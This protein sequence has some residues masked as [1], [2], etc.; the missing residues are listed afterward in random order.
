MAWAS[1]S[2]F[3]GPD[4][5]PGFPPGE[6]T[7]G[8]A[9][10][11]SLVFDFGG[12]LVD[13]AADIT[14]SV[15]C[16][17]QQRTSES[18]PA[19][20]GTLTVTLNNSSGAYTP[21]NPA[22]PH[23]PDLVLQ[24]A[25]TWSV[26]KNSNTITLFRGRV[27]SIDPT[28]TSASKDGTVTI[29]CSDR[30]GEAAGQ[31]LRSDVN[32]R[33][34]FQSDGTTDVWM[35]G[36]ADGASS[37]ANTGHGGKGL[38]AKRINPTSGRGQVTRDDADGLI[39]EGAVTVTDSGGV[40]PVIL[41]RHAPGQ[42]VMIVWFKWDVLPPYLPDYDVLLAG[43]KGRVDGEVDGAYLWHLRYTETAPGT[44]KFQLELRDT[45]NTVVGAL[46]P[47]AGDGAWH[48]LFVWNYEPGSTGFYYDNSSVSLAAGL[49]LADQEYIVCGG[50]MNPFIRG[51]QTHCMTA[52]FAALMV[53]SVYTGGGLEPYT[54]VGSVL[55]ADERWTNLM[56]WRTYGG[57]YGMAG[58][59]T[60]PVAVKSSAGRPQLDCL[61]ELAT[62]IGGTVWHNPVTD[63]VDLLTGPIYRP[64]VPAAV[65]V[66][67]LDDDVSAGHEWGLSLADSPTRA[68]ASCPA[69]EGTYI[70]AAAETRGV[71]DAG[72]F[73]TTAAT[74]EQARAL[75]AWQVNRIRRLSLSKFAV[76]VAS[77]VYG[78]TLWPA[79]L[80]LQP[81][82]RLHIVGIDQD[83]FGITTFDVHVIAWE[84]ELGPEVARW[85]FTCLPADSPAEYAVADELYGRIGWEDGDATASP[86]T[87]SGTSLTIT[88]PEFPLTVD[89][90]QYPLYLQID[91]EVLIVPSPPASSTSPQTVTVVRGSFGT[92]PVAHPAGRA[93]VV[94]PDVRV[95]P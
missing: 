93:P 64:Q 54:Q 67:E 2:T 72:T 28:F 39:V 87:V 50:G 43:R 94:W 69:G 89:P 75:A 88:A 56:E 33:F 21:D 83:V 53:S 9:D 86:L 26:T 29:T 38:S 58:P 41:A 92:V 40:G 62:T 73:E 27:D 18:E 30:L 17:Q 60:R 77:S 22:S 44:N 12:R 10:A 19:Q 8:P 74:V 59:D 78:P 61:T 11:Q 76:D 66:L 81:G 71:R 48:S 55:P 82:A 4:T 47:G 32:E 31:T 37:F 68:T 24:A 16:R 5:F 36:E 95:G 3:P 20:P 51:G 52:S 45:A 13:V 7:G 63:S 34:N 80:H 70:D 25:V 85:E 91:G 23:W 79:L 1:S 42:N 65:V 6:Y 15:T 84:L 46:D 49:D 90:A 35:F 14:G 57:T